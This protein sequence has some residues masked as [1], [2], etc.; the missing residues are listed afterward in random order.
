MEGNKRPWPNG[1]NRFDKMA[2]LLLGAG[3]GRGKLQSRQSGDT[4]TRYSAD[5]EPPLPFLPDEM[6]AE[7]IP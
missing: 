1:P 6:L 4:V 2:N 3:R 7:L 5:A